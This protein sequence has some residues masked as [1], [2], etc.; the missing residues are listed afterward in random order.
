VSAIDTLARRAGAVMLQTDGD[1]VA[2]HYGSPV[3]ELAVCVRAVGLGDRSD[4]GKLTIT[5]D[6]VRVAELVQR[7]TATA[8]TTDGIWYAGAAWWCVAADDSVTVLCEPHAKA[9]MLDMLRAQAHRMPGVE[10]AD[11]SQQWGAIAIVGEHA[12]KVL[13]ALGALGPAGELRTAKPFGS[14]MI[15][16]AEVRVLL[17]TDR[18]ALLL[19]DAEAAQDVWHAAEFAGRS[20][21]LSL[22][23]TEALRRFAMLDRP[24]VH[25]PAVTRP[26]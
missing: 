10:V 15:A 19:V 1:G 23:G 26:V 7:M 14:A 17:Q 9:R 21:G 22:V 2:A 24:G 4:L 20:F 16:G 8:I 13:A 3:A 18:R 12:P 11:R 5:G 25:A 6:P